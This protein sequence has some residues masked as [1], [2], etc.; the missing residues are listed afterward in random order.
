MSQPLQDVPQ[1]E[2]LESMLKERASV[3][4]Y[5]P[6][7]DLARVVMERLATE[8]SATYMHRRRLAVALAVVVLLLAGLLAVPQVRAAIADVLRLGAVRIL[9]IEPTATPSPTAA[10]SIAT[11]PGAAARAQPP[12]PAPTPRASPTA[13]ASVLD[14][15]GEMTLTEA[16]SRVRFP[17][18]LPTYPLDLGAPDRVYMQWLEGQAVVLVWLDKTAQAPQRVRLSLHLLGPGAIVDKV[19]PRVIR[20]TRVNG[21]RALWTE[22]P[23][24]LRQRDGDYTITRLIDGHVLIWTEGDITYRLETSESMEEAVKMAE[25]LAAQSP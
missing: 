10:P 14:L 15:S 1:F 9:L 8:P 16:Q 22:G 5:P 21:Q 11:I 6:T 2:S 19:R 7:P 3:F 13:L 20:E 24:L 23:Y 17:I 4:P 12:T 18:H 25:S